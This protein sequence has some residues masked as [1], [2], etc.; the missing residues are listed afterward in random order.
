MKLN[1]ST[2]S[3]LVVGGFSALGF[4]PSAH[5]VPG[6]LVNCHFL[7]SSD[8]GTENS[9]TVYKR[10]GDT[11]GSV[12]WSASPTDEDFVVGTG[13]VVLAIQEPTKTG[14][15]TYYIGK[16]G[17]NVTFTLRVNTDGPIPF[18]GHINASTSDNSVRYNLD[19]DL[20]CT[21]TN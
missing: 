19:Q 9:V 11:F 21:V 12:N 6:E 7:G 17:K 5:A 10:G 1:K 15:G 13:D 14:G 16:K 3:V 18:F 4:S 8:Q 2:L 20:N